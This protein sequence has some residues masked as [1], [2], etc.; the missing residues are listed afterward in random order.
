MNTEQ[1][2]QKLKDFLVRELQ[3]NTPNIAK[4]QEL[5]SQLSNLDENTVG[6]SV[7]AGIIDRLGRELVAKHETAVS[8]LVKNAYDA[9]ATKVDLIFSNSNKPGGTLWVRDNGHG[10]NREELI[11]GFMRLSSTDKIHH[12]I[13][14]IYKRQRAGR[15]GIGR[16]AAQRLGNRLVITTKREEQEKALQWSCYLL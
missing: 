14:P 11:N 4:I 5:T 7:D 13:S 10:M 1:E 2:K 15:K 16:F 6:F 9:D 3:S 8:E 12:P